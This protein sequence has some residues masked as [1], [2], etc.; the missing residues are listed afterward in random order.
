[1]RPPEISTDTAT[2]IDVVLHAL[3]W[4]ENQYNRGPAFVAVLQPTSPFRR[5]GMLRDAVAI[6]MKAPSV[7]AVVAMSKLHVTANY[8]YTGTDD[9]RRVSNAPETAY[10]PCGSIYLA[11]TSAFRS[12][13]SL[14]CTPLRALLVGACEAIDI[15]SEE[16]LNF[17]QAL[18][19]S[20]V[21]PQGGAGR[22]HPPTGATG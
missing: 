9:L 14:Y 4:Y 15:D 16:D 17:A 1:M 18:V 12:Q 8:L 19:D 20:G 11:R 10:E 7:A 22:V 3:D 13:R 6:L 21:I 2:T 5:E